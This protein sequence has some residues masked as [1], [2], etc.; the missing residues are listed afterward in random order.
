MDK[1][2]VVSRH[3]PSDPANYRDG[4]KKFLRQELP[5][6]LPD[7]TYIHDSWTQHIVMAMQQIRIEEI[8]Q[9]TRNKFYVYQELK[10]YCE[11]CADFIKSAP[12]RVVTTF[13]ETPEWDDGAPTGKIKVVQDGQFRDQ[14]FAIYTDVY[15]CLNGIYVRKPDAGGKI[16][17]SRIEGRYWQVQGDS[18]FDANANGTLAPLLRKHGI[19]YVETWFDPASGNIQGGYNEIQRI[20]NE[21]KLIVKEGILQRPTL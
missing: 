18:T 7:Q 11:V 8:M 1:N 16:T 5:K 10:K 4:I 12:C 17:T 3:A 20:Y 15:R 6:F 2:M 21:D 9:G 14:L 19:K 13:H